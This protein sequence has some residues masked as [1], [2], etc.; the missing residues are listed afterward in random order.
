[1]TQR[2]VRPAPRLRGAVAV[3]GDKSISHRAAIFN[4]LADGDATVENFLAG[5]DCLSTLA[6]LRSLGVESTLDASGS[7]PALHIRG[8]GIDGLREPA[9]V[10]DCGNSGTTMRLMSGVLA[11][12]PFHSVLT[13]DASLRARPMDRVA[14]PL[15]QMGARI[16]GRENGRFAPLVDPRRRPRRHPLRDAHGQRAGEVGRAARR[17]LRRRRDDGR[18]AGA[19]ARPHR[20]HARRDGRA[21]RARGPRCAAHARR[22]SAA[23]LNA[24]AE[25]RL[26]RGVLARGRRHPSRRRAATR[27]RR[28]EPHAHRHHRRPARDGRRHRRRGGTPGRRENRSPISSCARRRCAAR[29]ST[30][31]SSR[32]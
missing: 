28:H 10:L 2:E 16:D 15:R 17:A 19:D 27:R 26:G 1:M 20:A 25:R 12:Q 3:P 30:A 6:V 18:G 29:Q 22:S 13:G 21:R 23:A 11:G 9:D 5:E 8:A 31:R 4:A 24:R 14:T 7:R 32:A